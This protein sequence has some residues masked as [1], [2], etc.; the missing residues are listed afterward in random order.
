MRKMV[1]ALT[2]MFALSIAAFAYAQV[3]QVNTYEVT[4]STNPTKAGSSK[5]PVPISLS[6]STTRSASRTTIAPR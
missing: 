3:A 4:A 1:I 2:A 6:T 5:S